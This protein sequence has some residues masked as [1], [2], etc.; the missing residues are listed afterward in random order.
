VFIPQIL[1]EQNMFETAYRV[2]SRKHDDKALGLCLKNPNSSW[3]ITPSGQHLSSLLNY[4]FNS[5][6]PKLSKNK[7]MQLKY[8]FQKLCIGMNILKI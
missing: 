6:H 4:E 3:R 2:L 7:K 1:A 5:P 8:C